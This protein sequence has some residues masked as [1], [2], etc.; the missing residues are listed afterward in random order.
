M[1]S[2]PEMLK[3][4]QEETFDLVVIGGGI[5]GACAARDGARRGLRVLLL[6]RGDFAIGTSSRSSKLVHGGL[7]YLEHY[8]FGLVFESLAERA[9]L[10]RLAPHLVRPLP[11]LFPITRGNRKS[12]FVIGVGMWLYDALSLYRTPRIHSHLDRAQV[13]QVEPAM[14]QEGL[15]TAEVYYDYSTDDARLTLETVLDAVRAGAVALNQAELVSFQQDGSRRFKSLKFRDGVSGDT[16]EIPCSVVI[17]ATGPW[18]DA[19]RSL[20]LGETRPMVR[21]TKGVHIVVPH[22]RLPVNHA[23][24][25]LHPRDGRAPFAV[26]WGDCTYVGTTDTDW[27]GDL[28]RLAADGDDIRY[29]LEAIHTYYP[30][31]RV[32]PE[33]ILSTWTGVRPLVAE[34]GKKANEVS[35]EQ[36]IRA[37]AC[38]LVTIAGGKLTT[39]RRMGAQVVDKALEVH[40]SWG[41]ALNALKPAD[42]DTSP[43][44]GGQDWP[45]A[46][47]ED[48]VR[49]LESRA[50]GIL[51]QGTAD[52]LA[53]THGV[54]ARELV[55]LARANPRL[56]RPLC[57]GRPEVWAQVEWAVTHEMACTL[58]DV[59]Q[60]RTQVYLKTRDQGAGCAPEVARY[61]GTRLGWSPE[62]V[63]QEIRDYQDQVD[64]G[65]IWK[66]DL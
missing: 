39:C 9:V 44:P 49:D 3:R 13:A 58:G 42:T 15:R 30:S 27:S 21:P 47:G 29:L 14:N 18:T 56:A 17:N 57:P 50:E 66:R 63:E 16:C 51:P 35:R 19:V 22:E 8:Q 53:W 28:D 43:L 61:M 64:L 40:A 6:E 41:T 33:D 5:T 34:D 36:E 25:L 62:K 24:V 38:G 11:F 26:P 55:L 37:D 2:R 4:A 20:A 7:R 65:Q 46:G 52:H 23:V 45:A 12:P 31:C 54:Q 32:G 60:R 1:P 48:L 59:L 10:E